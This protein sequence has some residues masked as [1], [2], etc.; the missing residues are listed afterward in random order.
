MIRAEERPADIRLRLH[1]QRFRMRRAFE[2]WAECR[3]IHTERSN[4]AGGPSDIGNVEV[5][6]RCRA[7]KR[8]ERLL[9]VTLASQQTT[10]F[11]R[12][13]KEYDRASGPRQVRESL[14]GAKDR[15]HA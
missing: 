5:Q 8:H 6:D 15:S 2:D 12:R 1:G 3:P 14:C 13:C 9:N 11:G 4:V 7:R 10:F